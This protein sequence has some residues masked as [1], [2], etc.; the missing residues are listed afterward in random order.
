MEDEALRET[1]RRRAIERS[2]V[3]SIERFR[4]RMRS[5]LESMEP[6]SRATGNAMDV[7]DK[8]DGWKNEFGFTRRS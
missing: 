7:L 3:F 1:L 2:K 5:I 8:I 6:R 4:C